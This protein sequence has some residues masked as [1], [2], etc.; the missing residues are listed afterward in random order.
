MQK[1]H[2]YRERM[3]IEFA[4]IERLK[5]DFQSEKTPLRTYM[6]YQKVRQVAHGSCTYLIQEP[7]R[8]GGRISEPQ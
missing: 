3:K 8:V 5:D 6:P 1:R 2:E 7:K 4:K